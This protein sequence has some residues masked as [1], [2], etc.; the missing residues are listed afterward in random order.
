MY[1]TS[2]PKDNEKVTPR[3]GD[4]ELLTDKTNIPDEIMDSEKIPKKKTK[5][6]DELNRSKFGQHV[7]VLGLFIFFSDF[8]NSLFRNTT[9]QCL[10]ELVYIKRFKL[11]HEV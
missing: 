6:K 11:K 4:E 9:H 5:K 1:I 8:S 10:R 7:V 2:K 3:R